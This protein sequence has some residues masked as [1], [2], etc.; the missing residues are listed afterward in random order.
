VPLILVSSQRFTEH[1]TPPGHP[2]RPERAQ[3]M[4]TVAARWRGRGGEVVAPRAATHEQLQRVHD[5]YYVQRISELRD[6]AVALDP[7][8]Y[9]SPESYEVALLAA[10]AAIDAVERTMSGSHTYTFA[11]MRPPGHHAEHAHAMGFCLF[12]NVAVAAAHARHALGASRVAIVDY[13]VHHGNGTQHLFEHDPSV[14]YIS[15]HQYPYY[16]G[17]GAV[18]EIGIGAGEGFTVNLPMESGS[19]DADFE[20]VFERVALP[21]LRQFKPDLI[22]VSAGFDAH[23]R[24]PLAMMRATEAGFAAMTM[25]LRRIADDLCKGRLALVTEGGYDLTALD[26]SLQAVVDVLAG[27]TA[28]PK[29]PAATSAST[30]GK[31]SAEA[32]IRALGKHWTLK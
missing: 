28:A 17:T 18:G 1:Q 13:D 32:A 4:A 31:V 22:L 16:P 2:E 12:N 14:L 30:R 29:W 10:G 24:D 9:T 26:G 21:V 23:Q 19:I 8:T 25:A 11:M 3:V 6:R 15:T 7:D 5:P 20:H 27:D